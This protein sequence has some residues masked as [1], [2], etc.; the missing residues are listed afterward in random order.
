MC[1][2]VYVL[3]S[4]IEGFLEGVVADVTEQTAAKMFSVHQIDPIAIPEHLQEELPH[5]LP[6]GDCGCGCGCVCVCVCVCADE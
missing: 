3:T 4:A 1:V 6:E 2:C 5:H